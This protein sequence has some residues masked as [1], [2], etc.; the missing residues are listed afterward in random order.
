MKNNSKLLRFLTCLVLI[1]ALG[2]GA[3]ALNSTT[4]QDTILPECDCR[5]P[6]T[7]EYGV[8][9]ETKDG[10]ECVVAPCRPPEE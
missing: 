8:Q 1:I 5:Y 6:N 9:T 10:I 2:L 4:Q 3:C 7:G